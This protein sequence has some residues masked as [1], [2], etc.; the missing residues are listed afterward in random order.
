[1][2]ILHELCAVAMKPIRMTRRIKY[3]N[4]FIDRGLCNQYPACRRDGIKCAN[5]HLSSKNGPF[6][7]S[8]LSPLRLNVN[9]KPQKTVVVIGNGMVGHRFCERLIEFDVKRD[10]KIVTFCEEPRPAYDR[11]HLTQY[12]EHRS[13]EKLALS[14]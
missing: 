12:F 5:H 1:M 14:S 9:R 8:P 2:H 6:R 13:A 4:T 11:V 7:L 3:P 10:F